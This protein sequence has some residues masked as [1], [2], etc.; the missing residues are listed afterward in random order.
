MAVAVP[1]DKVVKAAVRLVTT[2]LTGMESWIPAGAFSTWREELP[3]VF[4]A[5]AMAVLTTTVVVAVPMPGSLL[6]ASTI[7]VVAELSAFEDAD[8]C[9][10]RALGVESALLL[11]LGVPS[12]VQSA[13]LACWDS[14]LTL[15]WTDLRLLGVAFGDG[16]GLERLCNSKIRLD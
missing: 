8:N 7:G 4:G 10:A 16:S 11:A 15:L 2:E 3:S 13:G 6:M 12:G 1:S 5:S 9:S 14:S